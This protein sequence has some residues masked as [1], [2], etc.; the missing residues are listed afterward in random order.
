MRLLVDEK[1]LPLRSDPGRTMLSDLPGHEFHCQDIPSRNAIARHEIVAIAGLGVAVASLIVAVI[2]L[3]RTPAENRDTDLLL[4]LMRQQID[5]NQC[6]VVE[7]KYDQNEILGVIALSGRPCEMAIR[8]PESMEVVVHLGA[9][10][11]EIYASAIEPDWRS[12][13]TD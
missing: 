9:T 5:R 11:S 3:L 1:L 7:I 13:I 6:P 2:Q 12:L 4:K 10:E 8:F